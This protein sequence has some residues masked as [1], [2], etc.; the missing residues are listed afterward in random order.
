MAN[1]SD[2][3]QLPWNSNISF[4]ATPDTNI[5][6]ALGWIAIPELSGFTT[7]RSWEVVPGAIMPFY[8]KSGV[9]A[10]AVK[11]ALISWPGK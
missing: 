1:D 4:S 11:R 8:V 9:D 3:G 2:S 7:N 5:S 10:S 6:A